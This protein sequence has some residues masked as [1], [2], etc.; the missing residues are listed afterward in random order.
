MSECDY[1]ELDPGIRDTVRLLRDAGFDTTDS[2]DGV[3][4]PQDWY[5]SG[6]AMPFPHVA[7]AA[8]PEVLLREAHRMQAVLGDGWTVEASFTTHDGSAIL[9]ARTLHE[10]ERER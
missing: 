5:D 1:G 8:A 7:A 3:S 6:E 10:R 2:G 9:L 4:K